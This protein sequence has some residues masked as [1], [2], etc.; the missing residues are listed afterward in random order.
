M[1]SNKPLPFYYVYGCGN[2]TAMQ[3]LHDMKAERLII[4][5]AFLM[6]R[7]HLA[8]REF[9]ETIQQNGQT[10][11]LDSG[12]FSAWRK[13]I[14]IDLA[15]YAGFVRKFRAYI[16]VAVSLDVINDGE[17]TYRNWVRFQELLQ[18][19]DDVHLM[20]V[21]HD[22]DPWEYYQKALSE[23]APV[24]GISPNNDFTALQKDRW[25]GRIF[26]ANPKSL[27]HGFGMTI[28]W[29]LK[30]YPFYTADSMSWLQGAAYG[31]VYAPSLEFQFV[32]TSERRANDKGG[33][34]LFGMAPDVV[35]KVRADFAHRGFTYEQLRD[36]QRSRER[37][38]VLCLQELELEINE[39]R[40]SAMPR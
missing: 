7:K 38:N 29:L 25:L 36:E 11:M 13:G 2:E 27:T 28:P 40:A 4:S 21:Y 18:D 14:V 32:V 17:G 34:H 35:A 1:P 39:G 26:A 20:T 9:F 10:L 33:Q 22:G 5:Y 24:L 3:T 31:C 30:K 6:G 15:E 8:V 16:T 19:V 23:E 37:Y 12:A